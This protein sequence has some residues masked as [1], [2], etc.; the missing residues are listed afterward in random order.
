MTL[1]DHQMITPPPYIGT[2][3]VC[4]VDKHIEPIVR[5]LFDNGIETTESCEGGEG[6]SFPEPTVR[7]CGDYEAGF[8]ALAIA[9]AHG[10]NVGELRRYWT[11]RNNEPHGPEWEMTFVLN[12]ARSLAVQ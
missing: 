11:I 1:L 6:H 5:I 4:C 2:T 12:D 10:F 7:F 3:D 8:R 9:I